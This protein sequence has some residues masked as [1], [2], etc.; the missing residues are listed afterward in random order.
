MYTKLLRSI[1]KFKRQMAGH[2]DITENG[3]DGGYSGHC[4]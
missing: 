2:C 3:D 1:M 4:Y